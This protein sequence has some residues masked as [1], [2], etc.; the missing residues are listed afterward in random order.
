MKK[1]KKEARETETSVFSLASPLEVFHIEVSNEICIHMNMLQVFPCAA[2]VVGIITPIHRLHAE[3][4]SHKSFI[5]CKWRCSDV[6]TFP[7]ENNANSIWNGR[8]A[9]NSPV[10]AIAACR[11]LAS[12]F[13]KRIL[14]ASIVCSKA[15][16][17]DR[18]HRV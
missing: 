5:R 1:T 8:M 13:V 9:T 18:N 12:A 4:I 3:T 17:K 15:L 2:I 6:Q 7:L 16:L 14:V 11:Q 10:I